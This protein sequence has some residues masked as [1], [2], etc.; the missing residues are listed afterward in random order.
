MVRSLLP[1]ARVG[2]SSAAAASGAA[3]PPGSPVVINPA[4]A[5]RAVVEFF[6]G[7]QLLTKEEF[8]QLLRKSQ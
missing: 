6:D 1:A 3:N 8:F 7:R 2:V 5:L 4:A